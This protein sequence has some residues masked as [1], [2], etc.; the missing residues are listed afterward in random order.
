MR[1]FPDM[2]GQ[3][4]R[5][6]KYPLDHWG[7]GNAMQ[8]YNEAAKLEERIRAT[9]ERLIDWEEVIEHGQ[10][11]KAVKQREDDFRQTWAAAMVN[12]AHT[13]TGKCPYCPQ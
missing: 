1:I 2:S 10:L 6:G 3:T 8:D 13:L 7:K 11:L 5:L 12:I 4:W 9:L